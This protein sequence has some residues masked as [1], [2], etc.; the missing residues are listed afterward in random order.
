MARNTVKEKLARDEVVASMTVRLVRTIEIA[1]IARTAGFDTLYV[2]LE[3]SSFS[4]ETCGQICMAAL[5]AG[6]APFVRVPANTPDYISRVLD[7]GALGV[8]APHIR[9]ADEAKAVVRAAKFPPLGERSN[10]GGR[11]LRRPQRRHHGR[12]AIRERRGARPRRGDRGGRRRRHGAGGPQRPVGGLGHSRRVR[13]SP[14]ARD[15]C[16]NHRDLP[17]ARQ[18]L[19]RRRARHASRSGSRV[20]EDGRAL[21]VDRHRSRLP[22]ERLRR[23]RATGQGDQALMSAQGAVE[24]ARVY[25]EAGAADAFA[26]RLL[27]AH[28]VPEDDAAIVAACLV[29]ADLRGVDTH[30]LCRLPGYLDRLRR[31][32]IN[33]RPVLAPARVT[34]VA[35]TLDGQNGFGFVVGTRAM[36]EAIAIARELGI[37]VVSARRST[38]FGMAAAYVLQALDAGL[39]ALVFSNASPAMPPWG[40]LSALLGTNPF[41]A[42]APAGRHP[43]FLLDMSPAVAARGKIRRVER[44]GEKIP[45]GYALDADGHP[46]SDPKAALGGVVLPIGTYKGSGLSMLMDIFGGVI[47]GANYGGD[48]GDQYKVYDR[49][50]DVGHFFLAMKPDLFVPQEDYRDRMD[51]LIERVHASPTAPDFEEVLMPGEPERRHEEERRRRGIP[52]STNETAALQEEA[53]KAGIAPLDVSPKPLGA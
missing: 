34:P 51:T 18:A 10:A 49:P 25:V 39:I 46:T 41:A 37:G 11:R 4:L 29:G 8:I 26:R 47:S 7:G 28:G 13:S 31:G 2:D 21:R 24:A 53:A 27:V 36:Q 9:S 14:R 1:R 19:R 3:H 45:L 22:A 12:R 38:H 52:Y 30:G 33:P 32:L 16:Q 42:G 17:Q 23:A 5:E 44:R 50:Q 20:R 40:A 43:P 15:L 6:I 35:A 48:V